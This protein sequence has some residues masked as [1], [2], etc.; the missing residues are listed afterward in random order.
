VALRVPA[1][2]YCYGAAAPFIFMSKII[3][4]FLSLPASTCMKDL[5]F[6]NMLKKLDVVTSALG[7]PQ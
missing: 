1:D 7:R 3:M 6:S 2:T 4:R 5:F